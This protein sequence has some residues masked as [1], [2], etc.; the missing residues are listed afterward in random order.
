MMGGATA[1]LQAQSL[2]A[3]ITLNAATTVSSF[4]PRNVFG[5]NTQY[6][7]S[8][9]GSTGYNGLDSNSVS[10]KTK[11]QRA[12]SYFLRYPGGSSSDTF[13]W[14]GTGS[15][16]AAADGSLGVTSGYWIPSSTAYSAGF[17]ANDVHMGSTSANARTNYSY[18]DDGSASTTWLSNVDTDYPDHQWVYLLLGNTAVSFNAVTITWGINYATSFQVQ[19]WTGAGT[20]VQNAE[21]AWVNSSAATVVGTGG[22]QGVTFTTVSSKYVRLLMTASSAPATAD[23]GPTTITGPAYSIAELK[24][25]NGATTVSNN[26]ANNTQSQGTASSMDPSSSFGYNPTFDFV[27]YMN[28]INSMTPAGIP[29]ITV[30]LGTGTPQEAA[31]WVHYANAVKGYQIHYWEIGNEMDGQWETGGPLNANEYARRY[32]EFY[33]AMQAEASTDGVPITIMGPVCSNPTANS[34]SNTAGSDYIPVF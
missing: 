28:Y 4:V 5:V 31:A 6:W 8:S 1:S 29:L 33:N 19:Y 30:N 16:M 3:T 32:I 24:V 10:V 23:L 18:L 13:H 34:N 17:E 2:P 21:S 25:Y 26:I 7:V 27:T 12:G 15:W 14:N 22:V 20:P 11:L 9:T